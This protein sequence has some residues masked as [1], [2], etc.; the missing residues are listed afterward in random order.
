VPGRFLTVAIPLS[1]VVVL[2]SHAVLA[3]AVLLGAER[4]AETGL[5]SAV[6]WRIIVVLGIETGLAAAALLWL[7]R[8]MAAIDQRQ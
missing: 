5:V 7:A 3:D 2:G 4:A 6:W 8:R 1:Y